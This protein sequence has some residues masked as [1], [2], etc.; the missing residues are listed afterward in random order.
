MI[1]PRR[2]AAVDFCNAYVRSMYRRDSGRFSLGRRRHVEALSPL[3]MIN[4]CRDKRMGRQ[5]TSRE[6]TKPDKA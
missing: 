6:K 1:S 4:E 5:V 3:R 2:V